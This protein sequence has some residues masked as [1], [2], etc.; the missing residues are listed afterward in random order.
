MQPPGAFP[1]AADPALNASRVLY[2]F[3]ATVGSD[4]TVFDVTAV[5]S[6]T[7]ADG[8]TVDF[9]S[10]SFLDRARALA[11]EQQKQ[12]GGPAFTLTRKGVMSTS[13]QLFSAAPPGQTGGGVLLAEASSGPLWKLGPWRIEFPAG[14][15][16]AEDGAPSAA[17][18][19]GHA[20]EIVSTG[21]GRASRG[22][23]VDSV[24]H[25]W[26]MEG[27]N[28]AALLTKL[29]PP[30]DGGGSVAAAQDGAKVRVEAARWAAKHPYDRDGVLVVD[31]ARVDLVVALA[32]CVARLRRVDSFEK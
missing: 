25:W 27:G 12:Q 32:T 30:P 31:E 1:I 9:T 14:G 26:A 18:H 4:I 19:C 2:L 3:N 7:I 17:A 23:A 29:V 11:V 5:L 15:G 28:R 10:H 6:D 13:L 21:M 16:G 24:P 20:L 22:F 8:A